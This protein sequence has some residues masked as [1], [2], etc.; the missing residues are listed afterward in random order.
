[1][2]QELKATGSEA[3]QQSLVTARNVV[4][5]ILHALLLK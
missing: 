4:Y 2:G 3:T 1:M 5:L